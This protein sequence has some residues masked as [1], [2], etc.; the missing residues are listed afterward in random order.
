MIFAWDLKTKQALLYSIFF[1]LALLS[2]KYYICK[3]ALTGCGYELGFSY[4]FY[5]LCYPA[6]LT[7]LTEFKQQPPA[8]FP[9]VLLHFHNIIS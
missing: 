2:G 4:T 5:C 6:W 7:A 1:K 8:I 9:F 3:C